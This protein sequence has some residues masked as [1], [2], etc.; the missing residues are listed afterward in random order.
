MNAVALDAEFGN[1]VYELWKELHVFR[2]DG[3]GYL[4]LPMRSGVRKKTTN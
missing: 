2:C 4:K 3:R 1:E